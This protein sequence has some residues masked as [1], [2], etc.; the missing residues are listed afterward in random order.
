MVRFASSLFFALSLVFGT[1]VIT[2]CDNKEEVMEVETQE[3]EMEVER[4]TE[5]G[6]LDVETE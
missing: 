5:T 4:D 1:A 6:E 2:G 3:G